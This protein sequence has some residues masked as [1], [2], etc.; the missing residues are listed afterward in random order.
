MI[1]EIFDKQIFIRLPGT[2]GNK[3]HRIILKELYQRQFFGFFTYLQNP[4][5]ACI[6][7]Y[8]HAIDADLT[9]IAFRTFILHKQMIKIT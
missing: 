7:N 2:T 5:E 4:V 9:Q 8:R 1:I 6:T 3:S